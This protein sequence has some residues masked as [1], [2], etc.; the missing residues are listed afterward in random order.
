M[1]HAE[2]KNVIQ[3]VAPEPFQSVVQHM[4]SATAISVMLDDH[5][6]PSSESDA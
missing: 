4:H 5:E 6:Y 1:L 3:T 2:D